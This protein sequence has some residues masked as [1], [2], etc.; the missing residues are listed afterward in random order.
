MQNLVRTYLSVC[1]HLPLMCL[2]VRPLSL[3]VFTCNWLPM[4]SFVTS[5][6]QLYWY[7]LRICLDIGFALSWHRLRIRLDIGFA[8]P[9]ALCKM[10]LRL[11]RKS[12]QR[13]YE[14]GGDQF[15]E[16]A[17]SEAR[18]TD[19]HPTRRSDCLL[20]IG[21]AVVLIST[22][23]SS[24]HR[25]RIILTSAAHFIDIG[26]ALT[27]TILET[28]PTLTLQN[29]Q[30]PFDIGFALSWHRLRIRF[31]IGFSLSWHRLRIWLTS[32]SH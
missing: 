31:D 5:A 13:V 30:I 12:S 4:I 3:L 27:L 7:R 14:L 24:R 6:S 2:Y 11:V 16:L 25:L 17:S 8:L 10:I 28:Q 23:H 22:S 26:F 1:F 20:D 15:H 29:S 18:G 21:F 9:E 32:A 19:P